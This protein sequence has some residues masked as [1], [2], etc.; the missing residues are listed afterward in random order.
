MVYGT[1]VL[2]KNR[3]EH[4]W[5]ECKQYELG[6]MPLVLR[7]LAAP[8]AV[9]LWKPVYRPTR[10]SSFTLS[11]TYSDSLRYVDLRPLQML[12]IDITWIA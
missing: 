4:I 11:L 8:Q 1:N 7:S 10:V 6:V 5:Y 2:E 12:P 9:L 3:R